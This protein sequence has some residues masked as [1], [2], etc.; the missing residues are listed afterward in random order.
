MACLDTNHTRNVKKCTASP[1]SLSLKPQKETAIL[2]AR[3]LKSA[4]LLTLLYLL[5]FFLRR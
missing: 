3:L 4:N 2:I 1:V 5:E